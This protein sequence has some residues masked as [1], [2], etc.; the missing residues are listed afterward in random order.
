MYLLLTPSSQNIAYSV[1]V[2]LTAIGK[3]T[4]PHNPIG[5]TLKAYYMHCIQVTHII[6]L[7]IIH[8]QY[9]PSYR[10]SCA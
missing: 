3:L 2:L 8:F 6:H 5:F 4:F 10:N 9:S 1:T 7:L